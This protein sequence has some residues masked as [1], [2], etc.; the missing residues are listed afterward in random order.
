MNILTLP[1]FYS[2]GDQEMQPH[3]KRKNYALVHTSIFI[4][5]HIERKTVDSERYDKAFS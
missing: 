2:V 3:K 5:L 4:L 1:S